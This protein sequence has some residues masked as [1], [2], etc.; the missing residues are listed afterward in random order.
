MNRHDLKRYIPE[1]LLSLLVAT[2]WLALG[3]LGM[4]WLWQNSY[5]IV[6][7]VASAALGLLAW[8]ISVFV[9]KRGTEEVR[10][11]LGNVANPSPSWSEDDTSAWA[12]VIRLVDKTAPFSF[13]ATEP[14]IAGVRQ[15]VQVAAAHFHSKSSNAWAQFSLP[16][17][18]VLTERLCR[19]VRREILKHVPGARVMTLGHLLWIRTQNDRYGAFASQGWK[20]G[21]TAWRMLRATVN[22]LQATVQETSN[23]VMLE[24]VK[25]LSYRLRAY[26]TRLLL[27]EVG[28]AAIDLYSGRLSLSE[29]DMREAREHDDSKVLQLGAPIR[30]TVIGRDDVGKSKV[31]SALANADGSVASVSRTA[32]ASLEYFVDRKERQCVILCDEPD[33]VH[34]TGLPSTIAASAERADLTLW[35]TSAVSPGDDLDRSGL[36][37]YRS[38]AKRQRS[39]KTP[40]IL[41]VLSHVDQLKPAEGGVE[42]ESIRAAVTA[43]SRALA[44]PEDSIVPVALQSA[45]S[46][47]NIEHLWTRI[48]MEFDAARLVQLDR[49]RA[50]Q[51]RVPIGEVGAQLRSILRRMY[52]GI[53]GG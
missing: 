3:F 35:V 18:L 5:M 36:R 16:E 39:R 20:I 34:G 29:D 11:A 17:A 31:V 37:E 50:K 4:I 19:D 21:F 22:P 13:T 24:A 49:Y 52:D 8:P 46:T 30:I 32:T 41:M 10:I 40:A 6:W 15:T 48:E 42:D 28:R 7:A 51:G 23:V 2:P 43:A 25:V 45:N 33:L 47:Y 14:I 1:L 38:W 26:I 53:F 12:E 44:V 9:R 27:L